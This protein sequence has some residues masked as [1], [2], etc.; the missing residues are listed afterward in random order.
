MSAQAHPS[1][2]SGRYGQCVMEFAKVKPYTKSND[3][4]AKVK[5]TILLSDRLRSTRRNTSAAFDHEALGS[6]M[7]VR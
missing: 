2:G 6:P 5:K 4:L 7:F 1:L 3:M